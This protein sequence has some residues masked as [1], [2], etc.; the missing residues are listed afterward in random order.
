MKRVTTEAM[1]VEGI[2]KTAAAG[3]VPAVP[4][5]VL[6]QAHKFELDG[7]QDPEVFAGRALGYALGIAY[8]V[9]IHPETGLPVHAHK[10][11]CEQIQ[12]KLTLRTQP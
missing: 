11:A 1:T 4:K 3:I 9:G 8:G 5:E 2:I 12:E 10:L 6:R 7:C